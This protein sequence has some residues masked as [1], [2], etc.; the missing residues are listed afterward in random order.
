MGDGRKAPLGFG[1]GHLLRTIGRWCA[2]QKF[3]HC[4]ARC[5]R[6]SAKISAVVGVGGSKCAWLIFSTEMAWMFLCREE[7]WM[8]GY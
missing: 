4:C 1:A 7:G 2:C 8:D 5:S 3:S 6:L